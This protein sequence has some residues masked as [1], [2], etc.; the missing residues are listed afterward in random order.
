MILALPLLITLLKAPAP[1]VIKEDPTTLTPTGALGPAIEAAKSLKCGMTRDQLKA[2]FKGVKP[3]DD[4]HTNPKT[5]EE[6]FT[7]EDVTS[8]VKDGVECSVNVWMGA[9]GNG[10]IKLGVVLVACAGVGD[11]PDHWGEV[12]PRVGVL[13]KLDC[14]KRPKKTVRPE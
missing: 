12:T 13:Y 5:K 14:V 4:K 11:P 9:P 2:V 6:S 7:W 3:P 10:P 1:D 8:Y